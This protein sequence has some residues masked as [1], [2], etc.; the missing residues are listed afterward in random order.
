MT[1]AEDSYACIEDIFEL[2][3]N[4]QHVGKK[5]LYHTRPPCM[6]LSL[7]YGQFLMK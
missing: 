3:S 7:Q 4:Q 1:I 5:V 6:V 2:G